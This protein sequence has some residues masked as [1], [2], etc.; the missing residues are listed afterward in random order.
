MVRKFSA[1]LLVLVIGIGTAFAEEII[2]TFS[3]FD[4]ERLTV[5]VHDAD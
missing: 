3:R 4:G 1:A 2:A 5:R